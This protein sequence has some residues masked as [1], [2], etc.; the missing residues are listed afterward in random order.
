MRMSGR[1]VGIAII[2]HRIE[3]RAGDPLREL[4]PPQQ[5][6]LFEHQVRHVCRTYDVV[7]AERLM[8]ATQARRRGRKF[9]L[10][11][12]F[13]DDLACHATVALPI[14]RESGATATFFLSGASLDRPFAFHFERLQRAFD[15]EVPGIAALVT[16]NPDATEPSFIHELVLMLEMMAPAARDAAAARLSLAAGPDPPTA[17]IRASQV[18]QLADAGMTIGFH[19]Y[20]HDSLTWLTEDELAQAM[21]TGRD[22]LAE[23]AGD[24]IN[25][26]AY[27]HGR[28]DQRVAAAARAAGFRSGFTTRQD[29]VTARSDPLLQGR[30][31]PSRR[32]VGAL[33]L[34]LVFT[35]LK[36]GS[37]RSVGLGDDLPECRPSLDPGKS[38]GISHSRS[39]ASEPQARRTAPRSRSRRAPG[40]RY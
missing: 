38:S 13:D 23:A 20:R 15:Q 36:S 26:I 5:A 9:P 8:E 1:K 25:T 30:V 22:A 12:T 17:G 2:Y 6:R 18:R 14:L 29:P 11:I 33:A 4:V 21:E 7:P 35:L 39:G 31:A 27:P 40:T 16:G 24:E 37:G 10:A 32:S 28:A 3:E 19:T 34:E